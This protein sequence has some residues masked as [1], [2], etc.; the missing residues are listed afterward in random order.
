MCSKNNFIVHEKDTQKE[1]IVTYDN[2]D[3]SYKDDNELYTHLYLLD[4]EEEI[5]V[6]EDISYISRQLDIL[7]NSNIN[8]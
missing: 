5:L 8:N 1:I 3:Y 2:Y 4:E 6:I 7:E